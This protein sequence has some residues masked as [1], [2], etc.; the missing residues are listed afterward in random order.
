MMQ[1]IQQDLAIWHNGATKQFLDL[2]DKF[3]TNFIITLSNSGQHSFHIQIISI[4][5]NVVIRRKNFNYQEQ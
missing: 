4:T 5:V 1:Q 3:M 2:K